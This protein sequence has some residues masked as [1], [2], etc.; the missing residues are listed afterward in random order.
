MAS[1]LVFL[2]LSPSSLQPLTPSILTANATM[3]VYKADKTMEKMYHAMVKEI[4]K[5][6]ANFG[7]TAA[8]LLILK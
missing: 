7:E 8:T 1:K 2:I 5:N 6:K 4:S 3:F